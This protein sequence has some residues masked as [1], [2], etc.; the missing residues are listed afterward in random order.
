MR[1][2]LLLILFAVCLSSCGVST[3]LYNWGGLGLSGTSAYEQLA[4]KN[5]DKQSPKSVCGLVSMYEGL[6][7]KPGGLRQVP[8]PG[9]CAEYGYLL[10]L[11]ETAVTFNENATDVQKKLFTSIEY[12]AF[13]R[14][15]GLELMAKEMEYYPESTKFI[16]PLIERFSKR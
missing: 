9:I 4:Y 7:T 15:Y 5:F 14:E 3:S 13:F 11:P 10:L 2:I 1:K 6:V 16:K 8:P 12:S